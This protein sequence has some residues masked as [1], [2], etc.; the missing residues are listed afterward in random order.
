MVSRFM[1]RDRA[2]AVGS[3]CPYCNEPMLPPERFPSVEHLRPVAKGGA[4]RDRANAIIACARC[5]NDK[6]NWTLPAFL[7]A[8]EAEGDPRAEHVRAFMAAATGEFS[9]LSPE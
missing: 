1:R 9:Q 4:P 3:L 5:N 2:A 8:L 6:G 7:A